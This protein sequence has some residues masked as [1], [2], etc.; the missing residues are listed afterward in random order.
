MKIRKYRKVPYVRDRQVE[1]GVNLNTIFTAIMLAVMVWVGT[2]IESIKEKISA[3]ATTLA[4]IQKQVEASEK[5]FDE[6]VK[7]K[8]LHK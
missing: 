8:R 3:F 6:H 4:V 5:R 7:D 1:I 2:N